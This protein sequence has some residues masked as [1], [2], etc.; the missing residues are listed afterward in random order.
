MSR[1]T[2]RAVRRTRALAH[3]QLG[4]LVAVLMASTAVVVCVI[5][6]A[7][8]VIGGRAAPATA[9]VQELLP[10]EPRL[11]APVTSG[12]SEAASVSALEP[13]G[14]ADSR[15]VNGEPAGLLP[16]ALDGTTATEIPVERLSD[17][18]SLGWAVPY[19]GRDGF[20][21]QL[22]ETRTADSER[23]IQVQLRDGTDFITVAET[24]AEADNA[25][26]LPLRE[27]IASLVD[28]SRVSPEAL[29]LTTG[30]E[31]ILYVSEHTEHTEVW[32]SAVETPSVQYVVTS[33]L[34]SAAAE[35]ITSW[36]MVTDRSRVH[37]AQ[38]SPGPADR[39]E[40]GFDE[41]LAWFETE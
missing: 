12:D 1:M 35:D 24:R 22:V 16:G 11:S 8:W 19:L 33:S 34:P 6:A 2:P 7:A 23:T 20:T 30:H 4:W 15:S 9:S 29:E 38:S 28:L 21:H 18:K 3:V 5:F 31:S 41:I 17:L 32:T 25:E 36:V 40:R 13:P 14:T 39:L 10:P 26:L 37:L 27:K